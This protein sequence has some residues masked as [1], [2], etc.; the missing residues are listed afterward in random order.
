MWDARASMFVDRRLRLDPAKG[1]TSHL[2]PV[3]SV[4]AYW[5]L[6]AGIPPREALPAFIDH[7]DNP[8]EFN[9]VSWQLRCSRAASAL[10]HHCLVLTAGV[11]SLR[12]AAAHQPS[13]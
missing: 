10:P 12:V 7:L 9:R 1:V 11:M 8:S 4:G 2:S 13:T 3:K 6:L 5:A